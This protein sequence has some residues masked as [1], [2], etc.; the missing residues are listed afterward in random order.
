MPVRGRMVL[1]DDGTLETQL[2]RTTVAGNVPV[3]RGVL[4]PATG[5]WSYALPAMAGVP[6]QTILVSPSDAPGIN[7]PL[8]LAG[9]VPL[10]E[11]I[12]HTGGEDSA[13]QE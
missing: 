8:G 7:G 3:V 6:G 13:P 1:R 10:P 5:Y 9:P 12:V 4:D 11:F 2:V